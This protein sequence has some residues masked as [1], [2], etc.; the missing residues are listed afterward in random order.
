MILDA[1]SMSVMWTLTLFLA[2]RLTVFFRRR[3]VYVKG[4]TY[5]RDD[6]PVAYWI[7]MTSLFLGIVVLGGVTAIVSLGDFGLLK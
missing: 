2:Y 4:V 3:E 7:Q 6:G 5:S 1:F